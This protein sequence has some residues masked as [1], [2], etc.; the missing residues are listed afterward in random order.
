MMELLQVVCH[1][2]AAQ[3]SDG[4]HLA[5]GKGRVQLLQ[6][7]KEDGEH[8]GGGADLLPALQRSDFCV[9]GNAGVYGVV[10]H[11]LSNPQV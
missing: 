8:R 6:A 4:G 5:F 10:V 2:K 9:G 3:F 1:V 7:G 11:N